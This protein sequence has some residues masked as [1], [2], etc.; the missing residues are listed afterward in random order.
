MQRSEGKK[1]TS[2]PTDQ[3]ELG[4]IR[5]PS[6]HSKSEVEPRPV[7]GF[8]L[9]RKKKGKRV[10]LQE[11]FEGENEDDDETYRGED[12]LLVG[13]GNE[14]VVGSHHS[15]VEMPEVREE[16]RS[17]ELRRSRRN[18]N[19]T[20]ER[21]VS[22]KNASDSRRRSKIDST[23]AFRSNATRCSSTYERR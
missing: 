7:E 2:R 1:E 4:H 13:I 10:S 20:I 15:D 8:L 11:G 19:T 3:V 12:V 16:R 6:V 22:F 18:C 23:H 14:S 17:V 5:S 9:G 21:P